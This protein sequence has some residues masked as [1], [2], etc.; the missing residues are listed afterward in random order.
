M[1]TTTTPATP[2]SP[3]KAYS[4]MPNSSRREL[5][6]MR[7]NDLCAWNGQWYETPIPRRNLAKA[8][9]IM[10]H[11]DSA[12]EA[13]HNILMTTMQP[14]NERWLSFD[15]LSK[16]A[17]DYLLY[18]DFFQFAHTNRIGGF[19]HM[20]FLPSLHSRIAKTE[21]VLLEDG[22][23]VGRYPIE[24]VLHLKRYDGRQERYGRPGY[25]SA[26]LSVYLGHA[27]TRFRY[28]Y[29]KNRSNTGFLL[30]LSGE[31]SEDTLDEIEDALAGGDDEQ[32]GNVIIHDAQ[33]NKD[34]IQLIPISD[35][36]N[37]DQFPE[38]KQLTIED[39]LAV[40]RVP[41]VLMGIVPKTTGGLGDP[42]KT[43]QVFARNEIT[44]FHLRFAA[45]N[46]FAGRELVRFTPYV[47]GD[48]G[49]G[50]G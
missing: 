2:P 10:P 6:W 9:D 21:S 28:Y 12:L 43:A 13:K 36:N 27:A 30:Y 7:G 35:K 42:I 40:H 45:I 8:L 14:V 32:F 44:P 3:I 26:L 5:S 41:P 25:L 16:A 4:I 50:N 34:K 38:V 48:G 19:D 22:L 11:H 29:V 46:R 37:Q 18:G 49:Q 15:D 17:Y 24:R 47:V 33:G 31:I 39:A 20:E 1:T 23:I